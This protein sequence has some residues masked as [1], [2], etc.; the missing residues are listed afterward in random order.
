MVLV[1]GISLPGEI[2]RVPLIFSIFLSYNK[3]ENLTF[4]RLLHVCVELSLYFS[5][6]HEE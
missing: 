3:Y 1:R 5:P 2:K 6:T 4:N